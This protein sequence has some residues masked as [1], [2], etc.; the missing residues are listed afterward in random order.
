V[1]LLGKTRTIDAERKNRH[2]AKRSGA[3][4]K[5]ATAS[6]IFSVLT[7]TR[8]ETEIALSYCKQSED[9]ILTGTDPHK[10]LGRKAACIM[11]DLME[12]RCLSFREIPQT[13]KLFSAF[14]EE[15]GRVSGYYAHPPT[16]TGTSAAA[17]EARV[18]PEIRSGVVDV[19]HEQN[20]RFGA[21]AATETNLDRLASG[22]VAIVTGQQVGLF[23]GPLF[24]FYKVLSAIR[25]A[26]DLTRRGVDA[27]PVFW[28]ATED[29]DLAEINH[30]FWNTRRGLTR[31]ELPV[32][33]E[34]AGRRVG[35]VMLGEE[36]SAIVGA[37]MNDLEGA[38]AEKMDRALRESYSPSETYGSSFGKLMARLLA[39]RGVI[40][41]DPLDERLHRLS[42]PVYRQALE[43]SES[44]GDALIARSNDLEQAGFHAQVK[45]TRETTLLFYQVD[46]RR[47]AVRS[48]NGKFV[49][50]KKSFSREELASLIESTPQDFTPNALL[51]P[52]V[53]DTLLPTAAYIGGPAEI[54]YMAQS[55]VPYQRILGR[56]PV[57]LPRASFTIVEPPI[58]RLMEKYGLDIRDI[59][60]GRQLLRGKLE[61]HTLPKALS[62]RFEKDEKALRSLLAAY[63]DPV[64]T[65]DTTLAGALQSAERK[66][67]YQFA[68][69]KGKAARAEGLR[70]G[71]L[72]RHERILLDSLY[73][74]RGLQERSL[75]TLPFLAA[76]GS[77]MLHDLGK[78][79][80][81]APSFDDAG[82]A[83]Q[84]HV[85]SL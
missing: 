74:N 68:K 5:S 45:V 31:Y 47:Q 50:G 42:I 26:E 78:L 36:I 61:L 83:F 76:Y 84:H 72:D 28:L 81:M 29:H 4:K 38:D 12:S 70:T 39:G 55:H 85:V 56:M 35:E 51:R 8:A 62:R 58:A 44:L 30:T 67:L 11:T 2:P 27:V 41:M 64:K 3:L 75:S 69:L 82:C 71:V 15:F 57:I 21:G 63:G 52:V 18:A 80:S 23:S 66:M 77:G 49:A 24:S 17:R 22:A 54:A 25:C 79:A 19:L 9:R 60:R 20:R 14:L 33:D 16:E 59:F 6:R 32:K 10:L 46:G 7:G 48:R 1:L 13:T 40:L 37:A 34:D 65:L 43:E 53:Q 73:P